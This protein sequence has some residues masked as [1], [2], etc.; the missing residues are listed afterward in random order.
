MRETVC[1]D[2]VGGER[3][4]L[5]AGAAVEVEVLFDL[6]FALAFGGF[7]DG[8]LDVAV[9]V[10]HDLGH[11]RGVFGG[12]VVVVEV[13]IEAEAHD[14]FVEPDPL[15]H[16]VPADVADAVVDVQQADGA[17][18]V[19][20]RRRR[21]SRGGRAAVVLALDEGVEGVAVGGDG[22]DDGAAVLVGGFGGLDDASG[23]AAGGFEP[24]L[25]GIVD[26]KRDGVD[27]IAVERDVVCDGVAG[28]R[29]W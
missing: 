23:A 11:E 25:A 16:G 14:V 26:P 4:V 7:V 12:D 2:V 27:A 17:R 20:L 1:E 5:D 10:G 24:A 9:A 22:G 19:I 3:D 13:L 28:A 29:G 15:V 21:D 18:D 6:R 8:E